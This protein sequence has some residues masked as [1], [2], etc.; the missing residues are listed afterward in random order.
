[1]KPFLAQGAL[2]AAQDL[3]DY[4][5]IRPVWPAMQR[6][7]D[8][9]KRTQFDSKWGLWYW[10]NAMQ[11]GADN[12]AARQQRPQRSKRHP[13]SRCLCLGDA[14]VRGNGRACHPAWRSRFS[15]CLSR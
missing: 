2:V 10:D 7:L 4:E 1:M 11:S 13:G 15:A 3:N 8:Y 6:I 12:N 14:R 9:R 5:W